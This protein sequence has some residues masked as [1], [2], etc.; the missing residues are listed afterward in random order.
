MKKKRKDLITT[1]GSLS[2]IPAV[3]FGIYIMIVAS[4]ILSSTTNDIMRYG[5]DD[6]RTKNIA[7]F[8]VSMLL[9]C[10]EAVFI[11]LGIQ[12]IKKETVFKGKILKCFSIISACYFAFSFICG[13]FLEK[14]K[15]DTFSLVVIG[16]LMITRII[17]LVFINKYNALVK[18]MSIGTVEPLNNNKSKHIEPTENGKG[19]KYCTN[20]GAI[21]TGADK[22]CGACGRK[23]DL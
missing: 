22:F 7:L 19:N 12:S 9:C 13:A 18:E 2:I 20:C 10:F 16:L 23:V 21:L 1:I 17:L 3:I 15:K 4:T 14:S 11:V 8:F 6:E 5:N